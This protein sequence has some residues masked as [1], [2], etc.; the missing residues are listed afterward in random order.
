[1]SRAVLAMAFIVAHFSAGG[2]P[3]QGGGPE[4]APAPAASGPSVRLA[5]A[6]DLIAARRDELH[7]PGLAF[8]VVDRDRVVLL[9]TMGLRPRVLESS[10][11]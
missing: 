6:R 7:I 2:E 11:R 5:R 3:L 10:D 9:A 8:V 1:M 4:P